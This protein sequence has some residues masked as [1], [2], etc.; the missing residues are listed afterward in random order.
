MR[1]CGTCPQLNIN[2]TD[3][4]VGRDVI[5]ELIDLTRKFNQYSWFHFICRYNNMCYVYATLCVIWLCKFTYQKMEKIE[6]INLIGLHFGWIWFWRNSNHKCTGKWTG[7]GS[8]IIFEH[9]PLLSHDWFVVF[10]HTHAHTSAKC[11]N[12][13]ISGAD[14]KPN[15][16]EVV[17]LLIFIH[18]FD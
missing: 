3:F 18:S 12:N 7:M 9:L 4:V 17:R 2:Q 5:F 11:G 10:N 14:E 8:T 1:A 6:I 15:Q 16:T 13:I